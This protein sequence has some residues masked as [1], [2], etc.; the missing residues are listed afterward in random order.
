MSFKGKR[1]PFYVGITTLVVAVV[2][3]LT[4]LFQWISY[5]ESTVAA[6]HTADRLFVEINDKTLGQYERSLE[7]LAVLA[8]SA[9]RMPGMG[10]LPGG[11]GMAHPGVDLMLDRKSVV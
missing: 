11:D 10:T 3:V 1:Y 4:G 2:V 6:M 7:S 8:G 9:A 5:R